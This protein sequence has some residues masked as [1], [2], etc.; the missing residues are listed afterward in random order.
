MRLKPRTPDATPHMVTYMLDQG[1]SGWR[2]LVT[3]GRQRT[4]SHTT[5]QEAAR[6]WNTGD[7]TPTVTLN[8]AIAAAALSD[9]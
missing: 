7:I 5:P 6:A 9:D 8:D 3:D 4:A 2:Y 1:Q